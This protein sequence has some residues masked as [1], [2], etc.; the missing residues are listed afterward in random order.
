M[1]TMVVVV[2]LT[3]ASGS[4]KTTLLSSVTAVRPTWHVI[5]VDDYFYVRIDTIIAFVL[6]AEQ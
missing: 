5:A 2:G 1:A 4:G 6:F 3:G